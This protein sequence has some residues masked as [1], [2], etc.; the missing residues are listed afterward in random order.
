MPERWKQ[1]TKETKGEPGAQAL[2]RFCPAPSPDRGRS[3]DT[4][5]TPLIDSCVAGIACAGD[6]YRN[7]LGLPERADQNSRDFDD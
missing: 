2:P 3:M 7:A 5:D 1:E 4:V 6:N